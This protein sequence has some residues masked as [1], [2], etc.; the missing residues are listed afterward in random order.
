MMFRLDWSSHLKNCE[1]SG[2]YSRQDWTP[3]QHEGDPRTRDSNTGIYRSQSH[4]QIVEFAQSC[5]QSRPHEHACRHV[6]RGI[7]ILYCHIVTKYYMR[8]CLC[9]LHALKLVTF[10][11]SSVNTA[12]GPSSQKEK[13]RERESALTYLTLLCE[14]D[15]ATKYLHYI[16]ECV[17]CAYQ[18]VQKA[19]MA[20]SALTKVSETWCKGQ[21]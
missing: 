3:Q 20:N 2:G 9:A 11:C 13:E 15:D 6:C 12:L 8:V 16:F 14:F 17:V 1:L 19:A 7:I 5:S 4:S 18:S 21:P 10:I